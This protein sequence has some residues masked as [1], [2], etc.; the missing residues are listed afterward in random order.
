MKRVFTINKMGEASNK[1]VHPYR[2]LVTGR[3]TMGKT[4]L[5]VDIIRS[6]LLKHVRRCFA[7]CP[8]FWSQPA[9]GPLRAI[10]GAFNQKNVFTEVHDGVFEVI[11]RILVKKPAP[12]LIFIDDSS[13]EKATNIGSKGS[14]SRL[15]ISCNHL[16]TSMVGVFHRLTS[17]SASFRDNCE[18]MISFIPSKIIDVDVI[19][20]EFNPS[21]AHAKSLDIVRNALQEA[22]E[23]DRFCFIARESFTGRIYYYSGFNFRIR[24]HAQPY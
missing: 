15:C 6:K 11:Y 20:K 17:A 5:A 4:T 8:T 2:L 14:F 9:L 1:I 19:Y 7:V 12:T 10:Q 23:N 13:A 24:F 22:W 21:P 3:S 16:D 18:G